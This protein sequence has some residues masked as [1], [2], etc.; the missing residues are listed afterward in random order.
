MKRTIIFLL[1]ALSLY[2]CEYGG[3]K[4]L[5]VDEVYCFDSNSYVASYKLVEEEIFDIEHKTLDTKEEQF[6]IHFKSRNSASLLNI[7]VVK[8]EKMYNLYQDLCVKH[9]DTQYKHTVRW[10]AYF[11][12]YEYFDLDPVKMDVVSDVD[13]DENHPKGTSLG[14]LFYFTSVTPY[15]FIKNG[16]KGDEFTQIRKHLNELTPEEMVLSIHN[17]NLKDECIDPLAQ[18]AS[19]DP[20]FILPHENLPTLSQQHTLTMTI[21]DDYGRKF[22]GMIE[23]DFSKTE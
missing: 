23:V 17:G 10:L 14:D 12:G 20:K 2:G 6:R 11:W 15:P 18:S 13:F 1:F 21:T 5:V 9:N 8:D 22:T 16:Y 19:A 7:E 3:N 4:Q